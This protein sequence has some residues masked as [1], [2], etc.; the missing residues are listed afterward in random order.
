M[1]PYK[2]ARTPSTAAQLREAGRQ[3]ARE[4]M[5]ESVARVFNGMRKPTT[6]TPPG[7]I[8]NSRKKIARPEPPENLS[9][10]SEDDVP[11]RVV[12]LTA[13]VLEGSGERHK[14]DSAEACRLLGD[15]TDRA[16]RKWVQQGLPVT[17]LASGELRFDTADVIAWYSVRRMLM[18][19]N[20]WAGD[21][22][23]TLERALRLHLEEQERGDGVCYP[24]PMAL[25]PLSHDHPCRE[26]ALRKAC[27]GLAPGG[28]PPG[29]Q[30]AVKLRPPRRWVE[31]D[32]FAE[33]DE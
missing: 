4:A 19:H 21:T 30:H 1:K 25:V 9:E 27:E 26:A 18:A 11:L 28:A 32:Y 5:T 29:Y 15:C 3:G 17:K 2:P 23:L 16:L 8:S 31:V 10:I 7:V 6:P 13:T 22:H 14:M 20:K 33:D 12:T 24:E